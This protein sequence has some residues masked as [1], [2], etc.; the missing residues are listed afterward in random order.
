[1]VLSYKQLS[2]TVASETVW[3]IKPELFSTWPNGFWTLHKAMRIFR[4]RSLPF[5]SNSAVA[6]TEGVGS[7]QVCSPHQ[8][9][10]L[11]SDWGRF[12]KWRFL[13]ERK[14]ERMLELPPNS[15]V[16]WLNVLL[17]PTNDTAMPPWFCN[18]TQVS[19]SYFGRTNTHKEER[20]GDR[21]KA[22]SRGKNRPHVGWFVTLIFLGCDITSVTGRLL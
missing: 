21:Q 8:Q 15:S 20:L 5:I 22:W 19:W 18:Q 13:L 1:M 10:H 7:F 3:P 12:L 14:V 2:L 6:S 4:G 17:H 11:S 16:S 9:H